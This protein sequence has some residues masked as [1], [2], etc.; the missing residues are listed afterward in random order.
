MH[1]NKVWLCVGPPPG[2][3]V[4]VIPPAPVH[5]TGPAAAGPDRADIWQTLEALTNRAILLDQDCESSEAISCPLRELWAKA[6]S[7]GE[8]RLRAKVH[9]IFFGGVTCRQNSVDFSVCV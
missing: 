8:C 4:S 1:F 6:W 2:E 7:L 9:R 5:P 3:Q